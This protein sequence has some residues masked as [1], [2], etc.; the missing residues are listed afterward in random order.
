VASGPSAST[1]RDGTSLL[2]R[3][4]FVGDLGMVMRYNLDNLRHNGHG[5]LVGATAAAK[6]AS[7]VGVAPAAAIGRA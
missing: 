4:V 5:Y 7:I 1:A 2:G 6:R 3:V